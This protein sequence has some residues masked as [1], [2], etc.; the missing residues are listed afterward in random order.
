MD[1]RADYIVHVMGDKAGGIGERIDRGS[2]NS[3]IRHEQ[4]QLINDALGAAI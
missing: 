1:L 2:R 3:L 4:P